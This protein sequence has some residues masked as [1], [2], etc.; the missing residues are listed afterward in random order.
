MNIGID[1]KTLSKRYTG[2][3]VYVHE[4]IKYFNEIDHNNQYY[5][6]SNKKLELDFELGTNFHVRLYKAITG[7]IGVMYQLSPL[8]KRDKI[9]V[10]WGPEHCLVCG[11]QPFKQVVTIHDL[12]VL[13]NSKVGTRYN[14]ILQR[15]MT[16]PSCRRADKVI[17]IS[18]ST[19]S[20][21]I[22]SIGI[23][24]DKVVVIYNGDS[25]YTGKSNTVEEKEVLEIEHKFKIKKLGY[26][27][28]VGS[29]EPRKN[30]DT[31]VKAY[32]VYRKNGGNA[33]LVLAG[34][35]GWKYKSVLKLIEESSYK[36]D[37]VMTGYVTD[38]EK[39][40][41][42]RN[43]ISLVFPSLWEGFGFPILEAMS[44]GTPVITCRN[45]SLPEVGGNYAYYLENAFDYKM[46][47]CL[48]FK[49]EGLSPLVRDSLSVSC[50]KWSQKFSRK[51][52]A[53]E[54]LNL[55]TQLY[56]QNNE[57]INNCK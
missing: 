53:V 1:V 44:V 20:D 22:S 2:I 27:L 35:L 19:A 12:S 11:K 51:K 7:S 36:L 15:V 55:F 42:Y 48:F 23:N 29:I 49:I 50:I 41:L 16:I 25:P 6:Y 52:C 13:H 17:A 30:I 24:K 10:F 3:A 45:S 34:G 14:A 21:V 26:F 57:G 56:I 47:S 4:M 43:A 46:L 40:Y 37:I 5:L 38:I 31:I 28:F 39:E 54:I 33:K 32:N 9:D 18:K 8:L